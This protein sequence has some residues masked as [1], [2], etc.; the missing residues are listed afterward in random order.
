M[1]KTINSHV[2]GYIAG[3]MS[4]K[5]WSEIQ[6]LAI[7]GPVNNADLQFINTSTSVKHLDL[8]EANTL[9]ELTAVSFYG[10][11]DIETISLSSKIN[12]IAKD[13]FEGCGKLKNIHISEQ[14][15]YYKSVDGILYSKEGFELIKCGAGREGE[16]RIEKGTKIIDELAINGCDKL[17]SILIPEGVE[18][19]EERGITLCDGISVLKL[20]STLKKI[21]SL[22]IRCCKNLKTIEVTPGN[23]KL[24]STGSSLLSKEQRYNRNHTVLVKVAEATEGDYET[25]QDVTFIDAQAFDGCEKITN[26]LISKNV[27]ECD[28]LMFYGTKSAVSVRCFGDTAPECH[29][30]YI[31][32][33]SLPVNYLY[34]PKG[35]YQVYHKAPYWNGF[36]FNIE[37]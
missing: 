3:L 37:M 17:E 22:S 29:R 25:P 10:N 12:H 1:M 24:T 11:N 7:I 32:H 35:K 16:L 8:H 36:L 31:R 15:S 27:K 2:A 34:V 28:E 21:S 9:T 26:F 23:S 5:E 14:N 13:C 30:S 19:I 6:E 20:P 4:E 33:K 18:T